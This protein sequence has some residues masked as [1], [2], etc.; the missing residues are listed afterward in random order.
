MVNKSY[1]VVKTNEDIPEN[2]FDSHVV[3]VAQ[4]GNMWMETN[5]DTYLFI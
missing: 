5:L 3:Y 4:I 1:K 2:T